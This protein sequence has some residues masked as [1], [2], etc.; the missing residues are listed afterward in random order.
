MAA[1]D[2][3]AVPADDV[4]ELYAVIG[5]LLLRTL[6]GLF[7]ITSEDAETAIYET[8]VCYLTSKP[9]G[10]PANWIIA[11]AVG[12]ARAQREICGAPFAGMLDSSEP[13]PDLPEPTIDVLK[14]ALARLSE[15]E[16]E[17]VQMAVFA[18][19]PVDQ[20]A[21]ALQITPAYVG[22]LVRRALEKLRTYIEE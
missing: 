9:P 6:P 2:P 4:E 8:F 20:V 21:A 7:H 10:S 19:M 17:A 11:G 1:D 3:H 14:R 5:G 16:R 15:R 13:E 22:K 12:K 18:K